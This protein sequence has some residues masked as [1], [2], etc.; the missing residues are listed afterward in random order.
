MRENNFWSR[1]READEI[2]EYEKYMAAYPAGR[3]VMDAE[4]RI[5]QIRAD[6][7]W[8][9][10]TGS[11]DKSALG[12]FIEQHDTSSHGVSARKELAE[13]WENEGDL[14]LTE[15][16]LEEAKNAYT[17]AEKILPS[18]GVAWKIGFVRSEELFA[19]FR[20]TH[21]IMEGERYLKECPKGIHFQTVRE[22]MY[23]LYSAE[24]DVAMKEKNYRKALYLF[25]RIIEYRRTDEIS[26]KA[27]RGKVSCE[28][29]VR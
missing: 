3:F 27:F 9:K 23:P 22:E 29:R 20:G 11:G 25:N 28:K 18:V 13:L 19:A 6:E 26:Q 4:K 12:A 16:K 14:H 21:G 2:A 1:T 5:F 8:A 10:T 17:E 24:A 15:L 7:M